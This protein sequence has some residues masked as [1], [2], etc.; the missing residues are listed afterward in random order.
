MSNP[1]RQTNRRPSSEADLRGL[2]AAAGAAL[3]APV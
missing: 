3:E 2:M 1:F